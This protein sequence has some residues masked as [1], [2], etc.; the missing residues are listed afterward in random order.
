MEVILMLRTSKKEPFFALEN[1]SKAYGGTI[2]LKE[3]NMN[4]NEGEFVCVLGNTGCGKSTLLKVMGGIERE[5]EGEIIFKGNRRPPKNTAK[6][7]RNFGMVFQ[8]DQLMDWR[9]VW[10][11]VRF[12]L[13]IF[14]LNDSRY[15][16][17]ID[18]ILESVG[19]EKFRNLYPMELSGGMRQR[20][21]IARALA[22]D[23]DV[24]FL[25]QP[26]DA[27]YA[28]TRRILSNELLKIWKTTRKTVVMITN[29]IE[30]ALFLGGRVFILSDIPSSIEGIWDVNIPFRERTGEIN[31]NPEFRFLHHE[32]REVLGKSD[33]RSPAIMG[34]R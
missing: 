29:S 19:L 11:N 24:L 4:V 16:S 25:D 26:F 27:V 30:E 5:E 33:R 34:G 32:I 21:A 20:V 22:H 13:E 17:G 18:R 1:V 8:Q 14:G 15:L 12:P 23:P 28:I 6:R 2:V 3:V 10:E 9:T 31:K 7:Q